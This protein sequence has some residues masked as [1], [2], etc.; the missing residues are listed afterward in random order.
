MT[1]HVLTMEIL[2]HFKDFKMQLSEIWHKRA[3]RDTCFQEEGIP[4]FH[5]GTC[6]KKVPLLSTGEF[7][8]NSAIS[9]YFCALSLVCNFRDCFQV[10]YTAFSLPIVI[11]INFA[12]NQIYTMS[13]KYSAQYL[14]ELTVVKNV[15]YNFAL[16]HVNNWAWYNAILFW[17]KKLFKHL[18]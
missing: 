14:I 2:P 5:K 13:Y 8:T 7:A 4:S 10:S 1:A 15:L 3:W 17:E 6:V 11:I 12:V 16:M 18:F 9:H